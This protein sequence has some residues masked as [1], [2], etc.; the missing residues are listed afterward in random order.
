MHHGFR[1]S[2]PVQSTEELVEHLTL[3]LAPKSRSPDSE[4][5]SSVVMAF[6]GQ[7]SAY[8]GMGKQLFHSCQS[9]RES[10]LSYQQICDSLGLPCVTHL[11]SGTKAGNA[12]EST[13]TQPSLAIVFIELALAELWRSWGVQPDLLIG[14]SLGE[15]SALCVSGVLSASDAFYL[16]GSRASILQRKCTSSTYGMLATSESKQKVEQVYRRGE[17]SSCEISCKNAPSQTVVSGLVDDL[18]QLKSQLNATGSKATF[19]KTPYGFHSAQVEPIL[20]EFEKSA[21]GI[22]FSVPKI[23]IASTLSGRVV[24]DRGI[25]SLKYLVRQAREPVD[26]LGALQ[27]CV[28]DGKV[29][30]QSVWIEVGPEASCLGMIRST[31]SLPMSRMLP[32]IKSSEEN[33][34]TISA[35][36]SSAYLAKLAIDWKAYHEEYLDA[37]TLLE[38]PSYAFDLKE[39]W[40]PYNHV[41]LGPEAA[42]TSTAP[43]AALQETP[44]PMTTCLQY[45]V[46][47]SLKDGSGSATFVSYTSDPKLYRL[48]QG[49]LVDGVA[50]CPASVFCDMAFTAAKYVYSKTNTSHSNVAMSLEDLEVIHPVI[51]STMDT[52]LKIE[53]K[54]TKSVN[55]SFVRVSYLS[56]SEGGLFHQNGGCRVRFA[57]KGDR[58]R[59]FA[60]TL[61]LVRKRADVIRVSAIAGEGHRLF[62]PIVYKLF[63][64]LVCY[65]ENYQGIEEA[66]LDSGYRESTARIQLR[67]CQDAGQFTYNPYWVDNLVHLA[68]FVL[69]G[70]VSKPNDIAYIAV[71]LDELHIIEELTEIGHYTCYVSVQDSS[72][73]KDILVGDAYVFSGEK[74]VVLCAGMRFQRMH[75]QILATI[76]DR[77]PSPTVKSTQSG[78]KAAV[79][80]DGHRMP[81][82]NPIS[83]EIRDPVVLK[84]QNG[85]VQKLVTD[86]KDNEDVADRLLKI[87]ESESSFTGEDMVPSTAFSEMGVDSL[88]TITIISAVKNQL[89][90]DLPAS[91]F[92]DNPTVKDVRQELGAATETGDDGSATPSSTTNEVIST[93]TDPLTKDSSVGEGRP[94][95]GDGNFTLPSAAPAISMQRPRARPVDDSGCQNPESPEPR[96]RP[97]LLQ[98]RGS[99]VETPLFL[100]TD[101]AGSATAYIH[102]PPLPNGRRIYALESPF[103]SD[104]LE[105]KCSVEEYCHFHV[106][107]IRENQPRGPYYLGGW[108]AGAVYAYEIARQ[109]SVRGEKIQ[110][111]FLIDMRVPRPMTDALEPTMELIEQAG[112]VTG[113][114]RTGQLMTE[115]STKLKQHFVSTV[116]ALTRFQPKPMDPAR[117]PVKSFM[118]WAKRG[119]SDE[120]SAR[121]RG[122]DKEEIDAQS[123]D[124]NVMEDAKTGLKGWFFAKRKVF[125]PN[126]WDEMLGEIECHTM[127]A[128]HFSMVQP[129][130]VSPHLGLL[131][132][133]LSLL[134]LLYLTTKR[135]LSDSC[136]PTTKFADA[137]LLSGR[138][139]R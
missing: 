50:L 12:T 53:V 65:G 38:L 13:V 51:V 25:F 84:S 33:W 115:A 80:R 119:I 120:G 58:N 128:D 8:P 15:Y 56:A 59:E 60:R 44:L 34:K 43:M 85:R 116:K 70:D 114:K 19:L 72:D 36:V 87:V 5:H 78:L 3:D 35:A 55:E 28:V 23:P 110:C 89:G 100:V 113:I 93:D 81:K 104:P 130:E 125:G 14:H 11:I 139:P 4:G 48:I 137:I 96:A 6:T 138:S 61:H 91:F 131:P 10:I 62:K 63:S 106:V 45:I 47:E 123:A 83:I 102:I 134:L 97:V 117:R 37:L 54:A 79:T 90:L 68:G 39:Y 118:V 57:P 124:A 86:Q 40:S 27:S 107:A 136:I 46:N 132:S 9:F 103:L 22:E 112:L 31:L 98:G 7:G 92:F 41:L 88:M 133:S 99:S 26:F 16:V 75:K 17:L 101:G 94:Q 126:G 69:N 42:R 127:E 29:D 21:M 52:S 108:S 109:L 82:A 95:K 71:G 66:F 121:I 73:K 77:S 30:E 20:D 2:F 105:F 1:A 111:L 49:H 32:T 18:K 135:P 24:S 67:T 122:L 76:L 74:L 129:P 64:N